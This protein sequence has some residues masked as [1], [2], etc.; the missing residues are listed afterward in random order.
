MRI[1]LIG[2]SGSGK[3]FWSGKLSRH[4]YQ[5]FSCDEL[6]AKRLE[7]RLSGRGEAIIQL[8]EWMGFPY[9]PGYAER[10]AEYLRCEKEILGEIFDGLEDPGRTPSTDVL[11]DTTGSVIYTGEQILA[12]LRRVTTVV[13][14]ATPASVREQ[15][16]RS[17]LAAPRPVLW[18]GMFVKAPHETD[19][20][21]LERCYAELLTTRERLYESFADMT[22]SHDMH[23]RSDFGADEFLKEVE[24]GKKRS[25]GSAAAD[26]PSGSGPDRA[27]NP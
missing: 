15:M 27:G 10:E 17:Y 16:V 24:R 7:A 21:A 19:R 5:I 9:D 25:G 23:R 14:L 8:G 18:Q 3:S 13:R 12:R 4:G 6:I 1:S 22:I 20:E 2:M 26:A 11:I